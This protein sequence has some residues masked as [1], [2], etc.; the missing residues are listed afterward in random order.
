MGMC[1]GNSQLSVIEITL[2]K[3]ISL[4]SSGNTINIIMETLHE[5]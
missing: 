4:E 2:T 3:L 5:P 1:F